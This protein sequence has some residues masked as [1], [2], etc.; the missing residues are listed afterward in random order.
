MNHNPFQS[1]QALANSLVVHSDGT[2]STTNRPAAT[3]AEASYAHTCMRELVCSRD[4]PCVGAKSAFN[5]HSYEIGV[6]AALGEEGS[7]EGLCHDLFD[8]LKGTPTAM[9]ERCPPTFTTF[10]SIFLQRNS[11]N[12]TDYHKR[13]WT[14]LQLIHDLDQ[15]YHEW[16]PN[17]SDDINSPQFGFSF[18]GTAFFVIGMSPVA[19]RKARLFN[20]DAVIWN[21]HSTFSKLR[22][23]GHFRLIRDC[24]RSRL[25]AQGDEPLSGLYDHGEAS[26]ALQYSGIVAHPCFLRRTGGNNAAQGVPP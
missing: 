13:F 3:L 5:R 21:L 15:R 23:D 4:Y 9:S 19:E 24:I 8:F 22:S 10:V 16:D 14:Q 20:Y 11:W 17:I 18:A 2:L 26:A 12:S 25:S 6:Y 1:K 7:T